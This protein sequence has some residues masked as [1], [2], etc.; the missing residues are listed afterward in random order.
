M[1]FRKRIRPCGKTAGAGLLV[2]LTLLAAEASAQVDVAL[3]RLLD[4]DDA[5]AWA[6]AEDFL[7]SQPVDAYLPADVALLGE[8]LRREQIARFPGLIRVAGAV[9]DAS[10][11][12]NV[13]AELLA[14]E[15]VSQQVYYARIRQGDGALARDLVARLAEMPLSAAYAERLVPDLVYTRARPVLDHLY[16]LIS[17]PQVQC[18]SPNP[19]VE[20]PIDCGYAIAEQLARATEQFPVALDFEGMFDTDDY[21]AA[22]ARV[23]RWYASHRDAYVIDRSE[24]Y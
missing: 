10:I 9:A 16:A 7:T 20:E 1:R 5:R 8:V 15:Y 4:T 21:P 12:A 19:Y 2:A 6:Q 23:R 24:I 22:L 3:R 17:V 18:R 11:W 13:P 14:D